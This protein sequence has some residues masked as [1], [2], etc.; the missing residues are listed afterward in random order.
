MKIF[1]AI[2][3][4]L[5]WLISTGKK[6]RNN[7]EVLGLQKYDCV[8]TEFRS[9]ERLEQE[10]HLKSEEIEKRREE[11]KG[12]LAELPMGR[13]HFFALF[14]IWSLVCFLLLLN[15]YDAVFPFVK[16]NLENSFE[17]LQRFRPVTLTGYQ[18]WL[19]ID[20]FVGVKPAGAAWLLVVYLIQSRL[21]WFKAYNFILFAGIITT[22]TLAWFGFCF[23]HLSFMPLI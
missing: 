16:G 4:G 9:L 15:F 6:C 21:L 8:V 1:K 14:T 10:P 17:Y 20:R 12:F 23:G 3:N 18:L 19:M 22:A 11:L 7:R 5:L 13:P 2:L